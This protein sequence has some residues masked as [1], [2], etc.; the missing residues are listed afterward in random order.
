MCNL[1]LTAEFYLHS[2]FILDGQG[3][4][5]YILCFSSH[6]LNLKHSAIFRLS[7]EKHH[8]YTLF[9]IMQYIWTHVLLR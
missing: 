9:L 7:H 8:F 6:P 3:Q 2:S 1:P 5:G 4:V